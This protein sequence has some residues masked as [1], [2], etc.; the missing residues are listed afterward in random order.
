MNVPK[1]QEKD[2]LLGVRI[3]KV[4][5]I[6]VDARMLIGANQITSLCRA[7][8]VRE[9]ITPKIM[10]RRMERRTI[11]RGV[12]RGLVEGWHG[13]GGVRTASTRMIFRQKRSSYLLPP[14]SSERLCSRHWPLLLSDRVDY[15]IR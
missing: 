1:T 9:Q 3:S 7:C 15:T 8:V 13:R 14:E 6:A 5:Q 2:C 10:R 12:L 4:M 11:W